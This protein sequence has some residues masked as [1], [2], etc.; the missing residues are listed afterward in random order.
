MYRMIAG[1]VP[2]V[3]AVIVVGLVAA[4][5]L[6][7]GALAQSLDEAAA[8]TRGGQ[9]YDNWY[10][11]LEMEA[12]AE[13]HPLYPAAGMQSGAV[14]WRCKECHGWDYKGADGAYGAGSHATGIK[15][16]NQMIGVDPAVILQTIRGEA[17]GYSSDLLT[18]MAAQKLALFVSLGQIDT[19][20]HIDRTTKMA[21]GSRGRGGQLY[22]MVC[23]SCHGHDG[24]R[25]NF[26][27]QAEPE[28]VGTVGAGNPWE[29]LHKIR[30][31]HPGAP[32][33]ALSGISDLT[34]SDQIAILA[35]TQ[36]LPVN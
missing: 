27:D 11:A 34:V 7:S 33:P 35:Y 31:G 5:A 26:G 17:H 25:I 19:D 21:S 29:M 16:L 20:L 18:D 28:Y 14:T 24:R 32:M 2:G 13:T 9:F 22:R 23:I 12:P 30:N 15:G 8:I 4:V 6:V 36:S 1:L 10:Q 3:R